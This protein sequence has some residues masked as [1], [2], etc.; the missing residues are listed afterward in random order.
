M[1]FTEQYKKNTICKFL[2]L[3]MGDKT[4]AAFVLK[5][6]SENEKGKE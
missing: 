3:A 2:S 5:M 4:L 6:V 1:S